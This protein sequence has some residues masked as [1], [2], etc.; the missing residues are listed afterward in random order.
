M[1]CIV[2]P[3]RDAAGGIVPSLTHLWTPT[4]IAR[5]PR[6][7]KRPQ[8]LRAFNQSGKRPSV[9]LALLDANH[10]SSGH[11]ALDADARTISSV[12]LWSYRAPAIRTRGSIVPLWYRT[13]SPAAHPEP[14]G[15]PSLR[16][17]RKCA[18]ARSI[19]YTIVFLHGEHGNRNALPRPTFTALRDRASRRRRWGRTQWRL[20]RTHPHLSCVPLAAAFSHSDKLPRA[21]PSLRSIFSRATFQGAQF[22]PGRAW[23]MRWH[24][25]S[26]R[27]AMFGVLPIAVAIKD[28]EPDNVGNARAANSDGAEMVEWLSLT[29]NVEGPPSW[30][31]ATNVLP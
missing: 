12:K 15:T 18:E 20:W 7:F 3:Y 25:E 29:L 5:V 9:P 8:E 10:G 28:I 17:L 21:L 4:P 14:R 2:P 27:T 30:S 16:S 11:L 19:A 24:S 1:I 31:T 22:S 26:I 13:N 6:S 23:K